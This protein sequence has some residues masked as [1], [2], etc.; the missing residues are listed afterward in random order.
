MA[1]ARIDTVGVGP[2]LSQ[3]VLHRLHEQ[4]QAP[5]RGH[6]Q[7]EGHRREGHGEEQLQHHL[8]DFQGPEESPRRGCLRMRER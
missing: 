6:V 7:R 5:D 3:Q 4:I 2:G 8:T 1:N